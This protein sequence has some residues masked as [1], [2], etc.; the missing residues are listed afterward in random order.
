ME[1]QTNLFIEDRI[2][3]FINFYIYLVIGR[4]ARLRHRSASACARAALVSAHPA[5]RPLRWRKHVMPH[6]TRHTF[7]YHLNV[8][9]FSEYT[10]KL[11]F[12]FSLNLRFFLLG[13]IP[14]RMS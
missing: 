13:A 6:E 4:N 2:F 11:L 10:K 5:A 9:V 14:Y 3:S 7:V 8:T 12:G 1:T